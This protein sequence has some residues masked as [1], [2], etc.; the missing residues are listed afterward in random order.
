MT[1]INVIGCDPSLT[2]TV[3]HHAH[4]SLCHVHLF[5]GCGCALEEV[6]LA[7]GEF[8]GALAKFAHPV[9]R[10][11]SLRLAFSSALLDRRDEAYGAGLFV[12]EGYA[13]GAMNAREALGEWGGAIRLSAYEQGWSLLIVPPTALKKFVLGKGVGEKNLMLREIS[14]R[15]NYDATDDDDGDAYALMQLGVQ[16]Q[17]WLSGEPVT[18]ATAALFEPKPVKKRGKEHWVSSVTYWARAE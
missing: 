10:L 18:K 15:W 17:R 4:G 16:Y 7:R 2:H 1:R 6:R 12:V 14:K 9:A 11:S 13:F 3:S 8:K 5:A